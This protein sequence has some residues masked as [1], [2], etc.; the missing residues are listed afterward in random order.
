MRFGFA[1]VEFPSLEAA[2]NFKK[3]DWLGK[4][5]SDDKRYRNSKIVKLDKYS[6]EYFEE[7]V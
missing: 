2:N 7:N 3:P 6:K 4:D 5:V 1:E